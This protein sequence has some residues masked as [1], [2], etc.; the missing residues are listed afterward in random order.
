M[1]TSLAA[2]VSAMPVETTLAMVP[3]HSWLLA[4]LAGVTGVYAPNKV[5]DDAK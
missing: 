1:L 5:E 2:V 4:L 3:L